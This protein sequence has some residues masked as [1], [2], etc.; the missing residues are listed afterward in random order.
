MLLIHLCAGRNKGLGRIE[1]MESP[2]QCWATGNRGGLADPPLPSTW[3]LPRL[4]AVALPG[5]G[6]LGLQAA[7]SRPCCS[8]PQSTPTC[9]VSSDGLRVGSDTDGSNAGCF[10]NRAAIATGLECCDEGQS[11]LATT[12]EGGEATRIH[13]TRLITR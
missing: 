13:W 1:S 9:I 4:L 10:Q 11:E 12:E 7:A 6:P 5:S 3:L 8:W 2:E